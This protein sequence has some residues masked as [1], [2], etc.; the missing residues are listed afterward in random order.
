ML[1]LTNKNVCILQVSSPDRFKVISSLDVLNKLCQLEKNESFIE[2]SFSS[3]Q[4]NHDLYIVMLSF[5]CP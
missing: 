1:N 2:N 4:V 3:D 5:S